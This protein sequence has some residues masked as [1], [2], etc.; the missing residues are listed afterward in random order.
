MLPLPS[1]FCFVLLLNVGSYKT[2]NSLRPQGIKEPLRANIQNRPVLFQVAEEGENI[3]T[4]TRIG[5]NLWKVSSTFFKF[6][7]FM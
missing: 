1:S 3:G 2:R 5:K 4:H 6:Y 7:Y